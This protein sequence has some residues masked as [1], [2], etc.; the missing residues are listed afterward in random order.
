[1]HRSRL[2]ALAV[3]LT[4]FATACGDSATTESTGG[5][6]TMVVRLTDAPFPTSEVQSV[7][8]FVVRVEGRASAVSDADADANLNNGASQGWQVLASPNAS[9][10]LL[11]LR[12]GATATL[13]STELASGLYNGF[14]LIIDPNQSSVTLKDGT[15]LTNTSSP[16]VTFPSASRSGIKINPTQPVQITAGQTTTLLVDFDLDQSFVM[17]GNSVAQNGL[18]FKPVIHATITDAATVNAMVRLA[19][20]T[21]TALD[22]LKS[23]TALTGGSNIG[24]GTSSTCSSVNAASPALTIA[25]TG[26]TTAL[27]GFTPTFTAG[28]SYT[29][30]AYP[31]TTG[32]VQFTTLD[33]TFTP[34][35]GQAGLRVFNAT[36]ELVPFDVYV[37]TSGAVL[38]TATVSNV[39]AAG[40]ST[41]VSVPAG[42]SQI[43][44]TAAGGQVVLL[45]LGTQTFTAG[46][47][48][49]LIIAPP[50]T[51]STTPRAF[52]VTGC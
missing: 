36:S 45:D 49:T 8:I 3:A 21:G 29:V 14:R 24:F 17:R 37:T 5:S 15:V 40:S 22:F 4:T 11:S 51:G 47:N 48:A 26:T 33:N 20:A 52:L 27:S 6:G 23:G 18:L 42:T 39:A 2:V 46:Q 50:A 25:N 16:S 31:T 30:V 9:F 44:L 1:M 28:T 10:D 35:S 13:G 41:F 34:A 12:N 7:D 38:G 19:N 43:R 32:G